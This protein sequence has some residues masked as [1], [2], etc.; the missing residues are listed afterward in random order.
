MIPVHAVTGYLAGHGW[1]EAEA[2]MVGIRGTGRVLWL[3]R[4]ETA[5]DAGDSLIG[6]WL[7]EAQAQ[8]E[9]VGADVGVLVTGRR[10]YGTARVATWWAHLDVQTVARIMRAGMVVPDTVAQHPMPM[11]LSMAVVLLRAAGLGT[12]L[13]TVA[14][15]P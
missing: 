1:P 7:D 14:V 2:T 8:A 11:Y 3:V 6:D 12:P 15:T 10:D 4:G 13:A 5:E 9:E